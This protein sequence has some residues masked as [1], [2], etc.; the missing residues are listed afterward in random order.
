[1]VTPLHPL[2]RYRLQQKMSQA[3]LARLLGVSRMRVNRIETGVRQVSIEMLV[4][5]AEKK[6]D[7]PLAAL[8]PDLKAILR[9]KRR[10]RE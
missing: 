7:L 2:M 6:I 10:R 9:R 8:R 5:I 4:K 1:M 3:A